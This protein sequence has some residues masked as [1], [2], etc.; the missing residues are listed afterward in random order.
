MKHHLFKTKKSFRKELKRQT[1][2]AIAAAVGFTIIYAWRESIIN[3][4]RSVVTKLIENTQVASSNILAALLI[5]VIGVLI[6]IISSKIL[7]D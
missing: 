6:I 2:Y 1:R 3:A 4:S 5:T 7:K